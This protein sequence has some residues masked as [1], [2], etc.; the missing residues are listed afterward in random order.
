MNIKLNNYNNKMKRVIISLLL[1]IA[2]SCNGPV[3][4]NWPC[5]WEVVPADCIDRDAMDEH[6]NANTALWNKVFAFLKDND[7]PSL[8]VG[9][10]EISGKDAFA[11]VSEYFP[12]DS[13]EC[14]FE[15]HRKYIDLQYVINGEEMIGI[16][17]TAGMSLSIP[18]TDD[19][20]YYGTSSNRAEYETATPDKFFVFFPKDA[21]RPS[22]TTGKDQL[23]PI[24]KIVVKVLF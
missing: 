22:L 6:Y 20:Q 19:I 2:I 3:N 15:T 21:H 7:L 4:C 12:K 13:S 24:K 8:A 16:A 14:R 5:G 10:Y 23:G 17:D 18:Y 1:L 9:E 11:I